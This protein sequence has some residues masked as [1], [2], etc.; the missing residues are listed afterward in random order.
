MNL[1]RTI[2][3]S[4]CTAMLAVFVAG[5]SSHAQVL[6]DKQN[7][8]LFGPVRSIQI[9]TFFPPNGGKSTDKHFVEIFYAPSGNKTEELRVAPNGVVSTK[10]SY[11]YD[12][13]GALTEVVTYKNDGS[14]SLRK[15]RS[16]S[17]D[18][19]ALRVE[20][21]IYEAGVNLRH[22]TITLKDKSARPIE[23]RVYAPNGDQESRQ[24]IAYAGPNPSEIAVFDGSNELTSR[25]RFLY[26]DG[27]MTE[28]NEFAEDGSLV[29]RTVFT[30]DT[31]RGT[32]YTASHY[33]ATGAL[34]EKE[35][36]D[37]EFDA[38]GNWIKQTRSQL[39]LM[40]GTWEVLEV[41]LRRITYY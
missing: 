11:R 10:T 29:E 40:S 18:S 12:A 16:E 32:R 13:D 17:E 20:E 5:C 3:I 28:Q 37:R 7:D 22:R 19:G 1:R 38:K 9:E 24:T 8:G 35:Q 34:T 15:S 33:D 31:T 41:T 30:G 36:Y 4:I 21:N 27:V 25:L 2:E 6:R 23:L 26:R 14:I 39:N